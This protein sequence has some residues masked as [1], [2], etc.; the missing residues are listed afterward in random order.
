MYDA[1]GVHANIFFRLLNRG[2]G[3]LFT[4]QGFTEL[5]CFPMPVDLGTI[6]RQRV[7]GRSSLRFC[8]NDSLVVCARRVRRWWEE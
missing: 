3:L 1:V 8:M 4:R 7:N 2:L 5:S 6:S